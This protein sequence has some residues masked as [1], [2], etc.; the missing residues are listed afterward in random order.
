VKRVVDLLSSVRL[1]LGLLFGLGLLFL[2][3]LFVPQKQVLQRELYEEWQRGSPT[4]V[5]ALEALRLTDVYRSPIAVV[6]WGAFFVNLAVVMAR[7]TAGL[8]RRTRI[9]GAIPDPSSP[10]FTVRSD[11]PGGGEGLAAVRR[12]FAGRG[13][14]VHEDGERLRAVKN[15]LAPLATLGFHLS[16][17]LVA[18]GAAASAATRFEGV[19]DLGEGEEFTGA[20]EQYASPPRLPSFGGPP[21][22]KFVVDAIR[23]EVVGNVPTALRVDLRVAGGDLQ[24]FEI[25]HPYV[26]RGTS[27]VFKNLGVAPLLVVEDARGEER[28]AGLMRL[29]VLNGRSETFRLVGQTIR[30]ELFPDYVRDAAGERTRSQEMRDPVLRL[31]S[32]HAS[33]RT[34]TASLRPGEAMTLG[35]YTLAFVDWRY[36][37]KLYVRSERG[38]WIV[39]LGFAIGAVSL[40]SRLFFY[41]REYVIAARPGPDGPVLR[42]AARSEF[43]RALFADEAEAVFRDLSR[44]LAARSDAEA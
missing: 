24:T 18:A 4:F 32:T 27:F 33:G 37:V 19:V 13:Y 22:V 35:P 9:D 23:P 10:G 43:Y 38:L 25:N 28:F 1:T 30:A 11:L 31:T 26:E 7:R 2:L 20:L 3:G 6:L 8:P 36:W 14:G 42:L 17:F 12:F 34:A 29:N 15:R 44:E 16:F 40:A 5:A 39:W 21:R 41:R